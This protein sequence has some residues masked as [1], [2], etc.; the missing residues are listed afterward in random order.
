MKKLLSKLPGLNSKSW[1]VRLLSYLAYGFL[2]LIIIA[3]VVPSTPTLEVYATAPTNAQSIEIKGKTRSNV[4]VTL[5]QDEKVILETKAT[6]SGDYSFQLDSLSEGEH[7][8]TIESCD[9]KGSNHC[10][11]QQTDITVDHTSP[12]PP[13]LDK[14]P[15]G[16]TTSKLTLTGEAE[17]ES[18]IVV[19]DGV[20]EYK[21]TTSEQNK[22]SIEIPTLKEGKNE[23]TV[24]SLDK[25]NNRS[26]RV[27]VTT[28]LKTPENERIYKVVKVVDGDTIAIEGGITIRYIGI[29][30]PETVDPRKPVQCYGVEA[31]AKNRELVEGKEIRLEKDVSEYDKYKRTLRAQMLIS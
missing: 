25:A 19:T 8:Y 29:D 14:I 10:T 21:T 9:K 4:P 1:L 20:N 18:E 16:I 24:S 13:A 23:L 11:K 17:L 7:A 26:E 30:T 22:F 31:S 12:E 6:S 2:A 27:T 3:I 15:P 28:T 5:T